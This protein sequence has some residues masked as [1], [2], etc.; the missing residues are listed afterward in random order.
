MEIDGKKVITGYSLDRNGN[1]RLPITHMNLVINDSGISIK[2]ILN[3]IGNR[4]SSVSTSDDLP[5]GDE[6]L[7]GSICYVINEKRYYSRSVNGWELLTAAGGGSSEPDDEEQPGGNTGGV[8]DIYSHIWVGPQPPED[9]RM[10]WVDTTLNDYLESETGESK[11]NKLSNQIL[12]L[13]EEITTLK[14]RVAYLEENGVIVGPGTP[15]DPDVSGD[16]YL[17]AEDGFELLLEDGEPMLL[18]KS[19][20][21]IPSVG[22]ALLTELGEELLLENGEILLLEIQ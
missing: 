1:I 10:I 18:E 4:L 7:L 13:M 15:D 21:V 6:I 9:T 19:T 12:E 16:S 5:S 17:L 8:E 20:E 2:D 22:N 14:D 3:D 11:L